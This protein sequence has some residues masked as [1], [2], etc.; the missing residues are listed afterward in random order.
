[1][2]GAYRARNASPVRYQ[3]QGEP[4]DSSTISPS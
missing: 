2:M 3:D 4:W 1:M